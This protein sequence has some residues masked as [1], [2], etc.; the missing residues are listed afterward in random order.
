MNQ[1]ADIITKFQS[2][3]P[4]VKAWIDNLLN[5][6]RNNAI[7]VANLNF[8]R[9]KQ[10][11]PPTLLEK[12]KVVYVLGKVPF[13]PLNSIGLSELSA[14]EEMPMAGI[15]YKDTFFVNQAHKTESLHFHEI[16]H[17]VQWE[18]LGIDNFLLAYGI[19]LL[20]FGYE[21]S[22]LEGMAYTLQRSFDTGNVP[23]NIVGLIQNQA[24]SIWNQ[25]SKI[26]GQD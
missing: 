11:F 3:L 17:V 10:I 16:V 23:S 22:P 24:D 9:I 25:V 26:I 14:M 18:R 8:S 20:Q 4:L 7:L 6:N 12:S 19:G 1:F 13:P 5:A 15:T 2:T 21:K